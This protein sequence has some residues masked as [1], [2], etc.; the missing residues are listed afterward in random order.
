[1]HLAMAA[2][3]VWA[4]VFSSTLLGSSNCLGLGYVSQCLQIFQ[5]FEKTMHANIECHH[6]L[7]HLKPKIFKLSW[8]AALDYFHVFPWNISGRWAAT[9]LLLS[10]VLL[11]LF[12]PWPRSLCR[13][14]GWADA[15]FISMTMIP[16]SSSRRSWSENNFSSQ[17]LQ[18]MYVLNF[19]IL[20]YLNILNEKIGRVLQ[21]ESS[22]SLLRASFSILFPPH[23]A[24][25][26]LE[27]HGVM[28]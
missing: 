21:A 4:A 27:V 1:M 14:R 15:P 6:K 17:L 12:P 16:W 18:N 8:V 3:W 26:Q 5:V 19:N 7:F 24:P 23:H 22:D 10:F 11:F 9:P 20:V 2:V 28:L 25:R 13:G